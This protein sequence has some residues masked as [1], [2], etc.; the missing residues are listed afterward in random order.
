[1]VPAS[2][3]TVVDVGCGSGLFGALAMRPGRRV[4]GIE[5]EWELARQAR[6]RLDMVLPVS[7]EYGLKAIRTPVP[8]VVFA[9]VLEHTS[10]P[11]RLLRLGAAALGPG[12]RIVVSFPNAAWAPVVRALAAGRWDAALAGVQA[13]DHLFFTTP[14]SFA[15]LAAECGLAVETMR[16][17]G[18]AASWQGRVWARLAALTAGG[19]A[20]ETAA[21]QWVAVLRAL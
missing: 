7:G 8:C 12:G 21:P 5:P 1:L 4:V 20:A 11:Q 14:R 9:D 19:S 17:L 3:R 16:P 18:A 6:S 13:R 10:A 2:A 15:N